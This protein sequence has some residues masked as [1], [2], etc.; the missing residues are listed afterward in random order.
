MTALKFLGAPVGTNLAGKTICGVVHA[1]RA[2]DDGGYELGAR[3]EEPG[4]FDELFTPE[5]AH[6]A[7]REPL[8][9][10]ARKSTR[11]CSS[12]G[13][14]S[15]SPPGSEDLLLRQCEKS[16]SDLD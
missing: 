11:P 15:A 6:D 1:L 13:W 12:H 2:A 3:W 5:E 7:L 4:L 9:A 8:R 14:V 16:L 10:C